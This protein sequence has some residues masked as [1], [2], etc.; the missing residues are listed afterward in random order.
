MVCHGRSLVGGQMLAFAS[1]TEI[2][3]MQHLWKRGGRTGIELA[4]VRLERALVVDLDLISGPS[5]P[6]ALDWKC[7][8][9]LELVSQHT[10]GG[11]GQERQGEEGKLHLVR[12]GR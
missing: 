7:N 4:A 12:F 11:S 9:D 8:I 1:P 10:D 6:L 5:L 2:G 3:A